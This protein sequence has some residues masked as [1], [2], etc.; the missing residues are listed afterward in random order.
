LNVAKAEGLAQLQ[1]LANHAD[2]LPINRLWIAFVSPTVLYKPGDKTLLGAGMQIPTTTSDAGF[3]DIA[4]AVDKLQSAGVEVFLSMGGWN[5]NCFPYFY[6]KY[7]VGGYGK[8]TPNY[9]KVQEFCNDDIT[10]ANRDNQYCYVC[11]PKSEGTDIDLDFAVFPEP[12]TPTWTA[13]TKYIEGKA[14]NPAPKWNPDFIPGKEVKDSKSGTTVKVPGDSAFHD[15]GRDPYVD[16][17]Y[18]AK[19][20]NV[21]G[22]DL[23][24]EEMW[25]ADYHKTGTDPGPY[26][27]E[28]T[29]YKY[30]A[31]LKDIEDAI[32]AN[33]PNLKLSTAAGA[34]GAWSGN[35]WGGNLEGLW[36]QVYQKFPELSKFMSEGPNAGGINVMTYDLSKNQKFHECPD[37]S[38]CELEKQVDFYM[39]TYK[40]AGIPA[41]VGYEIG[42]PAYPDPVHDKDNQLPLSEDKLST[43]ISNTQSKFGGGFFWEM[44]KPASGQASATAVAQALCKQLIRDDKKCSGVIPDATVAVV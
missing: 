14:S 43:L 26:H 44:Y 1:T 20:L 39:N 8:S 12:A 9:W 38:T 23:D 6:A 35:W 30:A 15:Q 2:T 29:T 36:L 32:K 22:I 28:Q 19:D 41:N 34:V 21:S 40:E 42:T 13:A 18:L 5:Y 25:H 7:S 4:T 16:F 37:D 10:N 3:A 31:I 24:Y 27:L 33:A 17:V 11:E